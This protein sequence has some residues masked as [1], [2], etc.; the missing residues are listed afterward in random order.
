MSILATFG[1]SLGGD[2]FQGH[3]IEN[4]WDW[5]WEG[6]VVLAPYCMLESNFAQISLPSCDV[7][8]MPERSVCVEDRETSSLVIMAGP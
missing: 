3:E 7:N 8:Y 2:W 1:A 4:G 5:K 6:I